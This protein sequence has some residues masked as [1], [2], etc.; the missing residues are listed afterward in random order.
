MKP[1][2]MLIL[3]LF[4][5][6][7]IARAQTDAAPANPLDPLTPLLGSWVVPPEHV[8]AR[9][10]LAGRIMHHYARSV[11]PHAYR[12]R[13]GLEAGKDS[14]A[15]FEGLIYW[16]PATER[17]EFVGVAGPGPGEGRFFRGEYRVHEDGRIE[18]VYDVFYRTL[19]DMP[20]EE[21]GGSRRRYREIYTVEGSRLHSTL[22]WWWDGGWKPFGPGEYELVRGEEP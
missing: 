12:I 17:I 4:L 21:H 20:G 15:E 10:E 2:L 13:E 16:D 22:D 3:S 18:R 11:G 1:I 14:D 5:L 9:P 8:E 6:S 7:P 19:A